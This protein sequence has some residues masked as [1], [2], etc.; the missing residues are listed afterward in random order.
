LIS[1]AEQHRM[2]THETL[3]HSDAIRGYRNLIHPGVEVRKSKETPIVT[4]D[5]VQL[6]WMVLKKVIS[7]I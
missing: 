6:A 7:E 2:F 4:E 1:V 5:N 3:K